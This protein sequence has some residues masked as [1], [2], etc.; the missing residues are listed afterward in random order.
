MCI[1]LSPYS[2]VPVHYRVPV[3]FSPLGLNDPTRFISIP[4]CDLGS[5]GS[6][7]V[8]AL[9]PRIDSGVSGKFLWKETPLDGSFALVTT[10]GYKMPCTIADSSV[11]CPESSWDINRLYKQCLG[12]GEDFSAPRGLQETPIFP[13]SLLFSF[14]VSISAFA[15]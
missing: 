10:A 9:R 6:W 2:V 12:N 13:C 3:P 8:R 15:F 11:V 5:I 1:K 14:Q 4:G 7:E